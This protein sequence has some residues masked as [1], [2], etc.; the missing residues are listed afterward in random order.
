MTRSDRPYAGKAAQNISKF[1]GSHEEPGDAG[2]KRT[3]NRQT[4]LSR[5]NAAIDYTGIDREAASVKV[6]PGEL[7]TFAT[8]AAKDR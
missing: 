8:G 3:R 4:K 1:K 7:K 5:T 6:P 2:G